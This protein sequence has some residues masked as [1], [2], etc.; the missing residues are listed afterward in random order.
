MEPENPVM[1]FGCGLILA[2]GGKIDAACA[3]FTCRSE[4]DDFFAQFGK[5]YAYALRGEGELAIE[6]ITEDLIGFATDDPEW[7]WHMAQCYSLSGDPEQSL[8]WL[9]NAVDQGMINYPMLAELDPLLENL[10]S[11]VGFEPLMGRVRRQWRS[12]EV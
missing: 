12:F 5:V 1:E 11:H 4:D 9:K 8:Q 2:M 10:R 6:A 3:I 7:A